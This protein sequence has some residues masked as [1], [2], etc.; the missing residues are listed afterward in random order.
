M[1]V[2]RRFRL[3]TYR[4]ARAGITF[5]QETDKTMKLTTLSLAIM[6]ALGVAACGGSDNGGNTPADPPSQ[7]PA[8]KAD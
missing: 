5:N 7:N 4:P 2:A 1:D 8:P 3:A 6:V